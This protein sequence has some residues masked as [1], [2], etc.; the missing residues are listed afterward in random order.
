MPVS[1]SSDRE[2][3][4]WAIIKSKM[5]TELRSRKDFYNSLASKALP[6][7]EQRHD[8]TRP[9]HE[10]RHGISGLRGRHPWRRNID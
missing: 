2:K 8:Q 1:S 5:V 4:V 9:P 10:T 7:L 3:S 6:Q